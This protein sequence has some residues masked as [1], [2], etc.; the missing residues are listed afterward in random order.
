MSRAFVKESD[1]DDGVALPELQVSGHRNLV[2]PRGMALIR[3]RVAALEAELSEARGRE[4]RAAM[5]RI[6]RDQ[7]YWSERLRTAEV[8]PLPTDSVEVRFGST[9]TLENPDG[10]RVS[11]QIVGEDEAAPR[12][13]RVSYVSPI[14]QALLGVQVGD[15]VVMGEGTVEVVGIR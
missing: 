3:E 13:G 2:T 4:D 10:R 8:V 14:G 6:Q 5:A 15:D 9:V 1:G 12:E 11:Y 7:R